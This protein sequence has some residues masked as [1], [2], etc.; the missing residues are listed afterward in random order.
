MIFKDD[1]MNKTKILDAVIVFIIAVLILLFASPVL[2][3]NMGIMGVALP[4]ILI[5]LIAIAAVL[6]RKDSVTQRLS[7][8]LPSIKSFFGAVVLMFGATAWQNAA[9]MIFVGLTGYTS[10]TDLTFFES[11]FDKASPFVILIVVALIPAVCEELFFRG[12]LLNCFKSKKHAPAIIITALLFAGIHLDVYKFFP[13]LIMAWAY[14]FIASKTESILL[15]VI[16]HFMNNALA[17]ISFYTMKNNPVEEGIALM[18]SQKTYIGYAVAALGFGLVLVYFGTRILS[19][20]HRKKRT[21]LITLITA[22]ALFTLGISMLMT[23]MVYIPYE[24]EYKNQIRQ[25]TEY[26]ESFS[27]ETE[28]YASIEASLRSSRKINCNIIISDSNDNVIY[29]HSNKNSS[30]DLLRL[31]PDEYTVTYSF[32]VDEDAAV[33][34]DVYAS[35]KVNCMSLSQTSSQE[36]D[37]TTEAYSEG[38]KAQETVETE[39]QSP[40]RNDNPEFSR[41]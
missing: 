41:A 33:A 7:L 38:S 26:T 24:G 31:Y 13:L 28:G 12:Y 39:T 15:P 22:G 35:V 32:D 16:F 20:K 6:L 36:A 18:L 29:D 21:T 14:G 5:A 40:N 34:Y 2:A 4:E 1:N 3:A 19:G 17:V 25:D 8:R 27:L 9:S 11:Y 37:E 23:S 30:S 10:N